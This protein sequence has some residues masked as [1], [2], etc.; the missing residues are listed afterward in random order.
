M[1]ETTTRVRI[2]HF[3]PHNEDCGVGKYQENYLRAMQDDPT[4]ENTFFDT[5]PYQTRVMPPHEFRQML[6]RLRETLASYDILH[7]QHEFALY[8]FD[9]FAEIVRTGKQAGKRLVITV[10]LAPGYAIK[11][12]SR[13]GLGPRSL[14]A[15]ARALRHYRKMKAQHIV[16]LSEADLLLVHNEVARQGLESFGVDPARIVKLSH[17]VYEVSPPP[18]SRIIKEALGYREGDVIYCITGFLHRYKG[19]LAAVRAL[20]FLPPHYKLA[21]LGGVKADSDDVEFEDKVTNLVD[22]LGLHDRVYITGYVPT[23]DQLNA[24][25]RECQVCVYP[26]DRVYYSNLSSG[27]LNLSFANGMPAIAYPT[28]TLVELAETAEGALVLC[29]TFAYYELARELQRID[30]PK[31]CE[32]SKKYAHEMAWSKV[33]QKLIA[34][35]HEQATLTR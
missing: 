18:I 8:W 10:H 31:Q 1:S 4:V 7:I 20:K 21:L 19:V 2:L 35:Y 11:R 32:L 29:E 30:I 3:S 15:Y 34:T 24:M 12:P 17:P 28:A 33:A 6:A 25:V 27:S 14:V 16:P 13:G 9:Q 23:D 26:Y 22:Q 5:S